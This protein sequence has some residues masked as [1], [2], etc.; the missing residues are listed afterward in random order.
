VQTYLEN[1][2][3]SAFL[4]LFVCFFVLQPI[5]IAQKIESDCLQMSS[6]GTK[7]IVSKIIDVFEKNGVCIKTIK[8]PRK[9]A[10][11]MLQNKLLDGQLFKGSSYEKEMKGI[12]VMIP[13]SIFTSKAYLITTSPEIHTIEDIKPGDYLYLNG[14]LLDNT[15]IKKHNLTGTGV[16]SIKLMPRLL[17]SGRGKVCFYNEHLYKKHKNKLPEHQIIH[18]QYTNHHIFLHK[19]RLD[20][21]DEINNIVIKHLASGGSFLQ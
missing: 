5:V 2:F 14:S 19:N 15:F 21:L 7:E 9:R 17:S 8:L 20:R 16:E 10:H 11:L 13:T 6:K 12:L 18:T 1:N 4:T 3:L